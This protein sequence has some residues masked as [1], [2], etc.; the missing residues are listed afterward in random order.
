MEEIKLVTKPNPTKLATKWALINVL[1]AIVTTYAFELFNA[2]P[3]S[4]FKYL[5]YIPFIA[6]L[7]LTQKEFRDSL[8]GFMNF[9]DAFSA[10]FRYS[11]FVGLMMAV[12][13]FLYLKV[14]SPDFFDKSLEM[15]RA[16]MEAKNMSDAQIEKAMGMAKSWGPLFAA[17]ATALTYPIFGAI[18]SLIGA[19][20]F[21]KER[22]ARD[23][24]DDAIDPTI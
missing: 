12:F 24:V 1:L 8:G 6:F 18:V 3:N 16:Q 17:F 13:I 23:L 9:G 15:S 21:K 19:A 14:L 10:G 7:F 11:M 20:I 22:T 4:P 2:D 5:G